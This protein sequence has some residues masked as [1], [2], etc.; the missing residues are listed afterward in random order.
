MAR[1]GSL[2]TIGPGPLTL[3][4]TC[5]KA[6]QYKPSSLTLPINFVVAIFAA[7]RSD[8]ASKKPPPFPPTGPVLLRRTRAH[9]VL[10][11]RGT[12]ASTTCH[13]APVVTGLKA[14]VPSV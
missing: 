14:S 2:K 10:D 12:V 11:G 3:L 8:S 5:V 9:D 6:P 4:Q 1:V 7:A 13:A